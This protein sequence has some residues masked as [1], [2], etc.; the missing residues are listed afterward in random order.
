MRSVSFQH[1]I[2]QFT[3]SLLLLKVCPDGVGVGHF[4]TG[5]ALPRDSS[6]MAGFSKSAIRDSNLGIRRKSAVVVPNHRSDQT[7]AR[8]L[9]ASPGGR[10]LCINSS[11]IGYAGSADRLGNDSLADVFM[12]RIVS[13]KT[14]RRRRLTRKYLPLGVEELVVIHHSG[15]K[16][17][18]SDSSLGLCDTGI[19]HSGAIGCLHSLRASNRVVE[20][21]RRRRR[22]G[23]GLSLH[24]GAATANNRENTEN[25]KIPNYRA[26]TDQDRYQW[27]IRFDE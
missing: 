24:S 11:V 22:W 7:T 18:A 23:S 16:G 13:N 21:N 26:F 6:E 15:K 14:N 4:A 9:K 19:G 10:C 25:T 1:R 3:L 2:V 27:L 17:G 12:N 5:L 8:D 20:G